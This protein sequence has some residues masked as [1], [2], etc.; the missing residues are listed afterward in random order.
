VENDFT[1]S[2]IFISPNPRSVLPESLRT[3]EPNKFSASV[4]Q[5]TDHDFRTSLVLLTKT[6]GLAGEPI[7]DFRISGCWRRRRIASSSP[8][9]E[10]GSGLPWNASHPWDKIY[11]EA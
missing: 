7:Q 9:L 8:S 3:A 6:K 1:P 11:A 2:L 10:E 4:S 5:T